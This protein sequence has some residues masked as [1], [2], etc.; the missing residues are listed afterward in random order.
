MGLPGSENSLTIGR[1]VLTK[2]QRVTDG[3]TDGRPSYSYN[4]RQSSDAG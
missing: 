2:Y 3:Q 4:V 1:A